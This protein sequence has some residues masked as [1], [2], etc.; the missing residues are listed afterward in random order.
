MF[1]GI[2]KTVSITSISDVSSFHLC[3]YTLIQPH[4]NWSTLSFRCAFIW[5]ISLACSS[6]SKG[7]NFFLWCLLSFCSILV[8]LYVGVLPHD[9]TVGVVYF[10]FVVLFVV[11]CKIWQTFFVF[12]HCLNSSYRTS[13]RFGSLTVPVDFEVVLFLA[14]SYLLTRILFDFP[15]A[16]TLLYQ[17]LNLQ[18]ESF[19]N[20]HWYLPVLEIVV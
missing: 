2:P 6:C 12:A 11:C 1:I 4:W 13:K 9:K 3:K 20:H 15:S 10:W 14:W 17:Q 5:S 19:W 18:K 16:G 7:I 8:S